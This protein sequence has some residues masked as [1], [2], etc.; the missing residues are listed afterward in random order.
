LPVEE[1]VRLLL[2]GFTLVSGRFRFLCDAGA[3]K[4]LDML[5]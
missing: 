3:V 5:L 4:K 2:D 1:I